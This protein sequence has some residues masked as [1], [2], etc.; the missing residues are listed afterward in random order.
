QRPY[1]YAHSSFTALVHGLDLG[2]L[3]VL[4]W[5]LAALFIGVMLA[6]TVLMSNLLFGDHRYRLVL[7]VGTA[8]LGTLALLLHFAGHWHPA[9]DLVSVKLLH[10]LQYPAI[11]LFLGAASMLRRSP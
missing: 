2:Q 1:S 6:L 9:F 10:L 5:L 11:L 3:V 8:V 4:K 7:A